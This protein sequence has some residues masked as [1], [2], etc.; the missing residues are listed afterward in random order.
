MPLAT[1]AALQR[2]AIYGSNW[3]TNNL[4]DSCAAFQSLYEAEPCCSGSLSGE[5]VCF[6]RP[7]AACELGWRA[8]ALGGL[9]RCLKLHPTAAW[10]KAEASAACAGE[11]ATLVEPRS[12]AD[13]AAVGALLGELDGDA[14]AWDYF[15]IGTT[16]DPQRDGRGRGVDVG[17]GRRRARARGV[18]HRGVAGRPADQLRRR[19]AGRAGGLRALPQGLR[20][21]RRR[22]LAGRRRGVHGAA[23]FG[24]V[25]GRRRGRRLR[26]RARRRVRR[27]GAVPE[28]ARRRGAQPD[29][30]E[31]R[32]ART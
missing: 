1:L 18:R 30:R 20:V 15:W 32:R 10:T 2:E 11:N 6:K 5:Y 27:P 29:G 22:L 9:T 7:V 16:Q 14:V 28:A 23:P 4:V 31:G 12:P 17:L 8:V 3:L 25:L 13:D 24:D 26:V 19:R 21:V